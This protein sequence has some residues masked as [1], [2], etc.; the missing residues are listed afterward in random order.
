MK[1]LYM[2]FLDLIHNYNNKI[3]KITKITK[4]I[5]KK[6]LHQVKVNIKN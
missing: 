5:N 4:I 6:I 1:T 3:L 2:K